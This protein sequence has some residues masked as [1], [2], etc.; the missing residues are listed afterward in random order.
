MEQLKQQLVGTTIPRFFYDTPTQPQA[1]FYALCDDDQPLLLVFLPNYGHPISRAYLPRYAQTLGALHSGRLACVVRSAPATIA[2]SLEGEFPFPLLCDPE[3]TLYDHFGVQRTA[4][5]LVWSITAGRI[6]RE[7]KKQG[8]RLEKGV[9]QQL[10]LTLAVGRGGL[11]LFAHYGQSLT[12]MPED[13]AAAEKVC[14]RLMAPVAAGAEGKKTAASAPPEQQPDPAADSD[15]MF[16]GRP[17]PTHAQAPVRR[18]PADDEDRTQP[19]DLGLTRPEAAPADEDLST[20]L[21][22]EP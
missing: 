7:A 6:F 16:P 12:D 11:V 3:G 19:I 13:C 8:Y 21:R 17:L 10:P 2:K 5:R 20:P 9:D 1:D 14:S 4:S 15:V 22:P 18:P